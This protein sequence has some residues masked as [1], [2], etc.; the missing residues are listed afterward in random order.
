MKKIT[1][2]IPEIIIGGDFT[3]EEL[4]EFLKVLVKYVNDGKTT[5]VALAL[6]KTEKGEFFTRIFDPDAV[7][8]MMKK[9]GMSAV[10][11]CFL[12]PQA[13]YNYSINAK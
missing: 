12:L 4:Y 11:A 7:E 10:D 6:Y 13:Y 5:P 3:S 2:S 1:K 9:Y 8:F